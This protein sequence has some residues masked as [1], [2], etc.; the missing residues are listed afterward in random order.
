MPDMQESTFVFRSCFGWLSRMNTLK[1]NVMTIIC[2]LLSNQLVVLLC[3][4]VR[5]SFSCHIK[6][7]LLLIM[8]V[9][10]LKV[11]H[12]KQEWSLCLQLSHFDS[13]FASSFLL[14]LHN[15]L[16]TDWRSNMFHSDMHTLMG[17]CPV[18]YCTSCLYIICLNQRLKALNFCLTC[19][20][21]FIYNAIFTKITLYCKSVCILIDK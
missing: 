7:Q 12:N 10:P 4:S 16:V 1:C 2:I 18:Q 21:N 5:L 17:G 11:G 13:F 9:W 6:A 19:F 8:R 14:M 20:S 3:V 15:S